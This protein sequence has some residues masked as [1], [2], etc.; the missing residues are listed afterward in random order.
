MSA[1]L[2]SGLCKAS[3]NRTLSSDVCPLLWLHSKDFKKASWS[4]LYLST[5]KNGNFT[6]VCRLSSGSFSI[7]SNFTPPNTCVDFWL[8]ALDFEKLQTLRLQTHVCPFPRLFVL[9]KAQNPTVSAT[10][11]V[12]FAQIS[13]CSKSIF[14]AWHVC[15]LLRIFFLM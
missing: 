4:K 15:P 12:A 10:C 9:G 8:S 13:K 6:Y 11:L 1:C 7:T 5:Q 2:C 3:K 14:R